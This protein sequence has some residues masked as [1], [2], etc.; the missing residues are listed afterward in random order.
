[1]HTHY[2]PAP[3]EIKS[4]DA[5]ARPVLSPFRTAWQEVWYAMPYIV[6]LAII[7]ALSVDLAITYQAEETASRMTGWHRGVAGSAGR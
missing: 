2:T 3:R 1:M 4:G 5:E 7:I 6:L